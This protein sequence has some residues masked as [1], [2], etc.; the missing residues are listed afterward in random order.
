MVVCVDTLR[1]LPLTTRSLAFVHRC[2]GDGGRA[3]PA[4]VRRLLQAARRLCSHTARH[5][6]TDAAGRS[7]ATGH[8]CAA[9][10]GRAVPR[11]RRHLFTPLRYGHSQGHLLTDA[12]ED[13]DRVQPGH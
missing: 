9:L 11:V 7:R 10:R 12:Q 8:A 13:A 4:I 5:D 2:C 1:V 6:G 3:R